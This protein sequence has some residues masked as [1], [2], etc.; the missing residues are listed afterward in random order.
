MIPED[1]FL[2]DFLS[3]IL[4]CKICMRKETTLCLKRIKGVSSSQ[5]Q[6]TP[7]QTTSR[8]CCTQ[9][10][11]CKPIFFTVYSSSNS[12]SS[13][14]KK[15]RSRTMR[16]QLWI[17]FRSWKRKLPPPVF[18]QRQKLCNQKQRLSHWTRK[19]RNKISLTHC[20]RSMK[21]IQKKRVK[22]LDWNL[23]SC[24]CEI[25]LNKLY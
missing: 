19:Q 6:S 23:F 1:S 12:Q 22:I 5:T 18:V 24:L 21:Q 7:N 9:C 20:K 13:K 25:I 3:Q 11:W 14:K 4:T 10:F 8:Y 16:M 2:I 17:W 15:R